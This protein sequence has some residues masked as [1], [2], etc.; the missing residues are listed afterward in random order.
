M[1]ERCPTMRLADGSVGYAARSCDDCW[2]AALA[3]V[4]QV[5]VHELPQLRIDE[6]LRAGSE[7]EEVN[8]SVSREIGDWLAARSLRMVVHQEVP[9]DAERWIGVVPIEGWFQSHCLVMRRGELLFDPAQHLRPHEAIRGSASRL[10]LLA[11]A[12]QASSPQVN[13]ALRDLRTAQQAAP[14]PWVWGAGD[15]RYGFTF[16]PLS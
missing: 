16:G 11:L 10:D 15:V 14:R 12:A 6:R 4:L 9:V 5:P 13:I 7:P 2:A 8:R 1:S 3:T